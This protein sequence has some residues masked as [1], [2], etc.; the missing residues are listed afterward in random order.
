MGYNMDSTKGRDRLGTLS[1]DTPYVDNYNTPYRLFQNMKTKQTLE[2]EAVS[3]KDVLA[4][5]VG[6]GIFRQVLFSE[7]ALAK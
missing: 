3:T 6:K 2:A 5:I 7:I 1:R 4:V